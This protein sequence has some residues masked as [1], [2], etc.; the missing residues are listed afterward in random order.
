VWAEFSQ[1]GPASY[2]LFILMAKKI[3][4][5]GAGI[6]GLTAGSCL[7]KAGYDVEIYEQA[8][9][10]SEIGA[11]IQLSANAMHVLN[12]LGLGEIIAKLSVRP[13]AYVFRLHDTGEIIGQ[14]PLAAE[15]ERLNGA[16]YNQLHRADLHDVLAAKAREFDAN[17]VRLNRRVVGFDETSAGVGLRLADG[18]TAKGDLLIGA[19]GVKSA[20]RAQIAGA[21]H[22]AYT[23]DAAWRLTL[24]TDQ[25]P[26]NFMGQV[27][28]VWMGPGAHV[29][30][31]YLRAGALFNFVGLVETEEISEESWT[32]KFPWER[33]KADF[34]GWHENIQT[35]IDRVDKHAC[36][37]WSLYY[38]PP[39]STW[40]TRRATLLG[41]AVHA[42]LPYLAQGA[43]M[44]IEDAAVL[45]RALQATDDAA[46]ALNLYERNRIPR[47]SRIVKGSGA[48]RTLFHMRDQ[49]KLRQKFAQRDEGADRNAWLYSYNPLTVKLT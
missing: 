27:M 48:N 30:C 10:L 26:D 13:G 45:T 20:V 25:L 34:V 8:P 36:F 15:H 24:P 5:A 14:F 28:S 42:T 12:H 18:S 44:A 39:I 41:D 9:E 11:G 33:L 31:Y 19:D 47:T 3:L 32:A 1:D 7:M 22:A 37:R 6:G 40:S 43:C 17:V 23:G 38:R 2:D 4:I 49:K 21:D 29:V 35:V 16:P 46:E